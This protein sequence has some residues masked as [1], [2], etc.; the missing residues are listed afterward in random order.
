[1]DSLEFLQNAWFLLLG[2]IFMGFSVLDGFDLG[3]G[4]L[5]RFLARDDDEKKELLNAI[6][7][8]W[9]GNE[10]WLLLAGGALFAA[11]P[12]AYATVFSGFYLAF[13]LVLFGLILRA[14]SIEFWFLHEERRKI[15]EWTFIMGSL[16]PSLLMGVALGNVIFGVPLDGKME[17][18]G[19]FL[20]LLR[21]YP[22]AVGLLGLSAIMMQ[23]CSYAALKTGGAVRARALSTLNTLWM[24][25]CGLFIL[26]A[27]LTGIFMPGNFHSAGGWICAILFVSSLGL[28]KSPF[29]RDRG[30]FIFILSSISFM[31]LWGIAGSVQYPFL[32]REAADQAL[33]ISIYNASSGR[34]SLLVML[35]IALAGMPAVVAYQA[36]VY[37]IFR[38]K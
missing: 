7:P 3:I 31:S 22:L 30:G 26:L 14:V 19:S 6:G 29:A 13:M 32:V 33:N 37:R 24:I 34:L 27:I 5:F 15:W 8:V 11:F 9:D 1:M 12:H 25:H 23:G 18:T 28:M 16:V 10:V 17:F 4:S 20:T 36:Y 2:I 21:P 35:I 38:K